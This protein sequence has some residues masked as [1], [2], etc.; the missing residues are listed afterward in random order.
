M[1]SGWSHLMWARSHAMWVQARSLVAVNVSRN[2]R[3]S[4]AE[5]FM[6]SSRCSYAHGETDAAR[7]GEVAGGHI[8]I[9]ELR[10]GF[11]ARRGYADAASS[12][13]WDFFTLQS[14]RH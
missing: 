10:R 2:R 7:G 8:F 9:V 12:S 14:E 1:I 4:Q 5:R 6:I 13:S 3:C 11:I